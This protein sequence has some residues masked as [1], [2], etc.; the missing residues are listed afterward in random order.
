MGSSTC[1]TVP[2]FAIKK[3]AVIGA[4]TMGAGIA[5][6]IAGAGIP[7]CLLD[8]VPPALTEEDKAKNVDPTSRAFRN[9]FAQTGKDRVCDPKRGSLYLP[10]Q[11]AMIQVGNIEDDLDLLR[12]CDWVVEVIVENLQAKKDLIQKVLQYLAPNAFLTSNTSGVSITAIAEDLPLETRKRFMGT[13]FF[14]PPRYMH[15]LELIPGADTCPERL[16]FMKGFGERVLGKGIVVAKD[17][18]NFIGNR[19]GVQKS[20]TTIQMM[21]KYGFDFEMVDYLTGPVIGRPKTASFGTTDLVGLDILYHVAGNVREKLLE[22]NNP[23]EANLFRFPDFVHEMYQ[24]KQLGN[25]TKG[26]FYK[27][28]T[29]LEGKKATLVWN[30]EKKEYVPKRKISIPVVEEALKCHNT[31]EKLLHLLA[32]DSEVGRFTWDT[33]KSMLLYSASKVPEI[34]DDYTDIDKAMRWGY[35]WEF[36]PFETWD[37]LGVEDTVRRMQADGDQVPQWVLDRLA[38]GKKTFY[39]HDPMDKRLSK[40]YPVIEEWDD[41]ALLDMG[42]GVL[43]LE[44]RTK[45]NA[46]N[47]G[48]KEQ[49]IRAV[50]LLEGTPEYRA[51]ILANSAA[52]FLTGADLTRFLARSES[53]DFEALKDSP[54]TF[55]KVSMRLKYSK[56]PIIAAVAGKALGGG[57]EFALHCSRVV[58]HA[59]ANLGLV[60]TGVGIIPGGGGVKE[61]LYRC[62]ER[63]EGFPFPDLNPVAKK[64]WETIMNAK[65]SRNAFD[66]KKMYYLRESD[67]IVMNRDLLLDAAKEEALRMCDDGFRQAVPRPVKVTGESGR[68]SLEYAIA[69]MR[70]GGFLSEYD[71]KV[72]NTLAWVVTGGDVP[73]GSMLS[74]AQMLNLEVEGVAQL[75]VTEQARERVRSILTTGKPL[76]N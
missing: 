48:F 36:G 67:R 72:A 60:E 5:A 59:E 71:Q 44:I 47:D 32:D 34:A 7:V 11:A 50:D 29:T 2:E 74:E 25:K 9:R 39:N 19:I 20:V 22:E 45:G 57:L 13:H 68:A 61:Y 3:A 28:I 17:T 14:N 76:R 21:E 64:V 53:G 8:I 69:N 35:N 63:V 15:L 4:G 55:H 42:G 66:A 33:T 37:L 73:K 16:A 41:S 54:R 30:L 23:Q 24:N 56:K 10:E 40:Y 52:N 46:I 27:K 70:K 18:P 65:V 38:A 58:A 26:G 51:M 75:V 62:M 31:K 1:G 12:D 6:L 49:T 43:C